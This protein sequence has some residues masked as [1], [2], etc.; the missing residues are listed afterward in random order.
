MN[1]YV[2]QKGPD[3]ITWLSLEPFLEDLKE[4]II[5]LMDMNL[6]LDEEEGRNQKLLGL[7]AT[8]EILSTLVQEANLNKIRNNTR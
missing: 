5:I 2:T 4:S 3:N 8:F 1:R 6:P 7:K